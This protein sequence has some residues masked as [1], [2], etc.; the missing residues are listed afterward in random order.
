MVG[1]PAPQLSA[2]PGG[3]GC[4]SAAR[5]ALASDRAQ[6][7]GWTAGRLRGVR[8]GERTGVTKINTAYPSEVVE[9]AQAVDVC[10]R[11]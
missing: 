10:Y 11:H 1:H 4:Q 8:C 7:R 5:S 9:R 2:P 6:D 3:P